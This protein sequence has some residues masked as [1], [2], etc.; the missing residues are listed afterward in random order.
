MSPYWRAVGRATVVLVAPNA[1][2]GNVWANC[3][4]LQVGAVICAVLVL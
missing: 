1:V 4:T 3:G 2:V